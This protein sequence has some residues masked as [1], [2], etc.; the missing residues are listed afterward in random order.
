MSYSNKCSCVLAVKRAI[1]IAG[2]QYKLAR[3]LTDLGVGV[4]QTAVFHWTTGNVN[5]QLE[6][7]FGIELITK[8]E[9]RAES[10]RE[11]LAELISR[12]RKLKK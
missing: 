7:A 4:S 8:G 11:D 10:I 9:V 6:Y 1:E 5:P 2:S 3:M 12:I